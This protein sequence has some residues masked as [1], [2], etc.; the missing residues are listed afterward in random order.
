MILKWLEDNISD[1]PRLI[2]KNAQA[3]TL[4]V[5]NL[6]KI[7]GV[8]DTSLLTSIRERAAP[9]KWEC[10]WEYLLGFLKATVSK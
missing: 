5:Q 2:K 3:Y 10:K 9:E 6:C 4:P 1:F 7:Q 8:P